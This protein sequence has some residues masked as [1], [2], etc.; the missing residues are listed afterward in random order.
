MNGFIFVL[1]NLKIIRYCV[2]SSRFTQSICAC[3]V[4]YDVN[5]AQL[6]VLQ[7]GRKVTLCFQ[8]DF[9]IVSFRDRKHFSNTTLTLV[10]ISNQ[11]NAFSPFQTKIQIT[12]LN[13]LSELPYVTA[14]QT[15]LSGLVVQFQLTHTQAVSATKWG[16]H[17]QGWNLIDQRS[18]VA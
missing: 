10:D 13:F 5:Q 3:L 17:L 8:S 4:T 15:C 11:I 14:N 1:F 16:R 9:G 12:L 6:I 7:P 18:L 2:F